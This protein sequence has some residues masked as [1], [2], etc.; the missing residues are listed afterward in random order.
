MSK[1]LFRKTL[2]APGLLGLVRRC[3]GRVE[4]PIPSRGLTLPDCPV[5][6][7][8]MFGL[9]YPSLLRFERD[10][11]GAE[12]VR[13]NLR[14]LYGVDRAPSDTAM[15]ERL[16]LV[17]PRSLRGAFRA[18]FSALLRGR[19][20]EEGF[21]WLGH[22][23]LSLDGTGYFSSG[24][25]HCANCCEKHHRDGR[26][27]Y[28]HQMLGAVL[29]HPERR[30]VFP[31]APEPVMRSDGSEKN[32]CERLRADA[33]GP[34]PLAHGE[35][36]L[37]HAGEPGLRLR[38]QPWPRQ[39]APGDGVRDA[40]HA[41][42]PHRPGAAALPR[43]FRAARKKEGRARYFWERLRSLFLEFIVPDWEAL[44]K[45]IAFGRAPGVLEPLDT[46]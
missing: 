27:T 8:A 22:H 16:D 18:V 32:D 24:S 21:T 34:R 1:T 43:G 42:L 13:S 3:F 6:A 39:A 31:L 15:R 9:K 28:H 44:Y 33:R 19:G 14:S 17:D 40:H 35:R 37:Q 25:V 29:V 46:Y 4:D 5:S 10:A 45:A 41:G 7:L 2:S 12:L 36:D 11:R 23:V 30:G 26:V 38:A 20:L